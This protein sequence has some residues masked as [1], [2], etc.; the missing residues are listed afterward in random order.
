MPWPGR[1]CGGTLTGM[2]VLTRDDV[3]SEPECAAL[4]A[5]TEAKGFDDAPITT[6]MGFLM[7]PEVRNNT[8]VMEDDEVR[9]RWLWGRMRS[10]IP[11]EYRGAGQYF[12]W[13]FDGPFRR[14]HEELSML[15]L[16]VYLSDGFCGGSTEFANAAPVVPKRGMAVVFDHGVRHRGAPVLSG[17]KYVLRTDVMYRRATKSA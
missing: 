16:M 11:A 12:E 15:T 14:S 7:V 8:R 3:L 4:V 17:T 1:P 6:P 2:D 10:C 5:E 9:A 13:H